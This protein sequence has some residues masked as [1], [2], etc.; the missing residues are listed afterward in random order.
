MVPGDPGKL[1]AVRA[2]AGLHVEIVALGQ[3]LRPALAPGV[4]HGDPVLIVVIVVHVGDPAPV[5]RDDRRGGLAERRRDRPSRPAPQRHA[6]EPARL[7]H[8]EV[9]VSPMDGE[10]AAAVA[11]LRT[12]VQ[13][14]A[15][16]ARGIV[17]SALGQ[18]HA[19]PRAPLEPHQRA[20]VGVPAG[21]LQAPVLGQASRRHKARPPSVRPGRLF[22]HR[23]PRK[24]AYQLALPLSPGRHREPMVALHVHARAAVGHGPHQHRLVWP[25]VVAGIVSGGLGPGVVAEGGQVEHGGEEVLDDLAALMGDVSGHGEGLQV[26]LGAHHRRADVQERAFL[27]AR[28]ALGEDQEVAVGGRTGGGRVEVGVLVEDVLPDRHVH[29]HRHA[30]AHARRQHARLAEG[31]LAFLDHAPDR[32]AEADSCSGRGDGRF[33]DPARFLPQ[34]ELA[35]AHVAGHALAGPADQGQLEVVDRP[36]P[37]Q[38]HVREQAALHEVDQ[39]R[40]VARAEH[41]GPAAEHDGAA[42]AGGGHDAPGDLGDRRVVERLARAG[43]VDH[44]RAIH[45]VDPLRQRPQLQP[46]AVKRLERH[47]G[48]LSFFTTE[49]GRTRR[50]AQTVGWAKP[51]L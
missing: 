47:R 10:I 20:P 15:E 49:G 41:V 1:P 9:R 37:V 39:Q 26:D 11:D 32:L 13:I 4:D 22:G 14:R 43:W 31:E 6:I 46:A 44:H 3:H 50:K 17:R 48:P 35:G 29:R 7:V 40:P 2:P 8:H 24:D 45:V 21:A 16:L 36:G 23:Q 42:G 34:P 12:H 33:V 18:E 38:R 28:D 27:Q 51:P 25:E 19:P 5:G 30:Q